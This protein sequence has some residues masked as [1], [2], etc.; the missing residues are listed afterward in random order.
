MIILFII[1]FLICFGY[2][3]FVYA[4]FNVSSISESFYM[5]EK[6]KS[7]L[8]VLF[9]GWSTVTALTLLP[10]WL[11]VTPEGFQFLA[12][13]S[14]VSL[15]AVGC[16]PKYRDE[17]SK[18]HP[19]F[20]GLSLILAIIWSSLIGMIIVPILCLFLTALVIFLFNIKRFKKHGI[21][22]TLNQAS[23]MFWME[24]A[25]FNSMYS[26]ILHKILN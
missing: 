16:V 5:F 8:G 6:K 2:S 7:G 13:L 26:C 20:T 3:A 12:F 17:H 9:W 23:F 10:L 24:L 25:A 4:T 19:L 1:S 21:K 14:S 22:E 11:E 18:L 15:I